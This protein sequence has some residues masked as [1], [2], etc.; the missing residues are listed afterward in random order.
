MKVSYGWLKEYVDIPWTPEELADRLTMV[1]VKVEGIENLG[2]DIVGLVAGRIERIEPHPAADRLKVCTV[3]VG[4]R[5]AAAEGAGRSTLTIVTGA[6][7]VKEGDVVAVALPGAT[8]PNGLRVEEA[9]FRGVRSQGMMCAV[10]EILFGEPH[11]ENEGVLVLHGVS[12]GADLVEVLGLRDCVLEL[13]LTPNYSPCLCMLGVAREVAALTGGEIRTVSAEKVGRVGLR[14]G[15]DKRVG[16]RIEDPDLCSR[17]V[18]KVV[19]GVKVGPSPVWLQRRLQAAGLRPIN[20]VVDVTNYVMMEMG[21]PLHAF[22]LD[23]VRDGS[24]I[25]RRAAEG[26]SIVTLDGVKR[27]LTQDMLVIADPRGP[28][29]VAG[30]MGGLETEVTESTRNVL[31]E[32]AFFDPLSVRRTA[33]ALGIRSEASLRFEKKVDPAGQLAAAERAAD[34]MR[35]VAY[36]LPDEDVVDCHPRPA[37]PVVLELRTDRVNT[38]LG[39]TLSDG[40]VAEYLR[41]YGFEVSEGAGVNVVTVPTRRVDISEE[42]DLIEEVARLY[43]YERVKPTLLRGSSHGVGRTRER[44]LARAAREAAL[45]CGFTEVQTYSMIDPAAYDRLRLP[46]DSPLR[47]AVSLANPLVEEQSVLRTTLIP[48][49]LDVLRTNLNHRVTDVLVF[50]IGRVFVPATMPLEDLPKEPV[51]LCMA[52][53]GSRTARTWSNRPEEADFFFLKGALEAVLRR[54]GA[55]RVRFVPG[56]WPSF[57]PHRCAKIFLGS[58]EIGVVGEIHPETRASYGIAGRAVVAEVD[59]TRT[60]PLCSAEVRY[61]PLPRYPAVDRDVAV[62]TPEE[63]PAAEVQRII[64]E[65]GG[66]LLRSVTLFD[67][68]R[69]APIPAGWRSLAFSLT[70]RADDRTLT[71]EEVDCIHAKVRAA[72]EANGFVLR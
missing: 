44:T 57:H 30:V 32:S 20:N 13:D 18:A 14:D 53:M 40:E 71:D 35:A 70:Y 37:S 31:I 28:I 56:G 68:Y 10:T 62:A 45:A 29:A 3:D 49:I 66:G 19:R 65:A 21:Q 25:V 43:G 47:S 8:L 52:A 72:L 36:G 42:V 2:Q 67:L 7:N 46:P 54:A 1:G 12:V 27:S 5:A 64:E 69:G 58:E 48:G 59:L 4:Q 55:S 61:S 15:G 39:E 17:Y 50:E 41:K 26:E 24:I 11:R 34:L 16:V 6:D 22:D 9:D 60:W 51:H 23:S 38:V 33:F 63:V